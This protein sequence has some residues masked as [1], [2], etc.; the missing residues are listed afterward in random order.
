MS[1]KSL[2][3]RSMKSVRRSSV[4]AMQPKSVNAVNGH[5]DEEDGKREGS[6]CEDVVHYLPGQHN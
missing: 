2:N 3:N 1:Q 5:I 4:K 6:D